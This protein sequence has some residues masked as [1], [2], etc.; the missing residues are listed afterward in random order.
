MS[1]TNRRR[2]G[3]GAQL[4]RMP[5]ENH[6]APRRSLTADDLFRLHLLSD[7]QLAPDGRQ[8][9]YV[10]QRTDLEKNQY[11]SNLWLV[12]AAGRRARAFTSGDHHDASPRWSPDGARIAFISDRNETSQLWSIP[13]DGGEAAALTRL[14]EGS[15]GALHWSPRG[16]RIAFTYRAKPVET[17]KAAREE[18]EKGHRSPPPQVIR[19]LHFREEGA[20]YVGAEQWQVYVLDVETGAVRQLTHRRAD[21]GH[22]AWSPDGARLAYLTNL[23]PDPYLTPQFDEILVLPVEGGEERR[24]EAPA[25]PKHHLAWSPDGEH[26]AYCGHTDVADVWSAADPHLWVVPLS[27]GGASDL[28]AKLDRPVG[29]HTLSDLRSFG[30]GWTGPVWTPDCQSVITLVSDRG[31]VHAYRFFLRGPGE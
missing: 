16:D 2:N 13:V 26:L 28:T 6:N 9:I 1:T 15:I 23:C 21:A 8:A 24:V 20:G 12:D 30:G 19:A 3:D 29:D 25:G 14:E 27:G 22:L 11:F 7:P 10:S 5:S 17:R 18:R 4:S 31:A